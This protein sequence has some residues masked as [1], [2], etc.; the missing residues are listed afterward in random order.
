MV[1]GN[2]LKSVVVVVFSGKNISKYSL[3]DKSKSMKYV[4]STMSHAKT[5]YSL[6][7]VNHVNCYIIIEFRTMDRKFM[8]FVYSSN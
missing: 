5:L 3:I 8:Y 2:H 4:P 7:F 6:L 1:C